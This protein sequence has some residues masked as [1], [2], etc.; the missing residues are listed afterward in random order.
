MA[1]DRMRRFRIDRV[2]VATGGH[3]TKARQ[4]RRRYATSDRRA[5]LLDQLKKEVD[6]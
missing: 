6:K 5:D 2:P 4:P 3:R 1:K